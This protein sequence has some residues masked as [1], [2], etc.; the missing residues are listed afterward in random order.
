[1]GEG[2]AV[3]QLLMLNQGDAAVLYC[4]VG[5]SE[6][7][8]MLAVLAVCAAIAILFTQFGSAGA[9]TKEVAAQ[10]EAAWIFCAHDL[11]RQQKSRSGLQ[12]AE[13]LS[14]PSPWI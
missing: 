1:M 3:I 4:S 5:F 6:I 8:G 2:N 9:A 11:S 14:V 7:L 10:L 12:W 13:P